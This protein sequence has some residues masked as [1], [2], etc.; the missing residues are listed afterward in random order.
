MRRF[1]IL[2]LI[3]VFVISEGQAAQDGGDGRSYIVSATDVNESSFNM[4]FHQDL[5]HRDPGPYGYDAWKQDW[6]N[7]PW[8]DGI[9]YGDGTV[10]VDHQG[11]GRS[12]KAMRWIFPEN[13]YSITMEHGY[14]W[15]PPLGG[16]YQEAYL[17]YSLMFK[18][19]FEPVL[20][21]KLPCLMGYPFD[22]SQDY[23]H[24]YYAGLMFKEG[25]KP[26]F[27]LY[28]H[29]MA[30]EY[31]E[32]R[33]WNFDFDVSQEIWYDIT[34]RVV[35][36]TVSNGKGN[37]DGIIEGYVNGVLVGQWTNLR[38]RNFDNIG[39]NAAVMQAF[40]G[41]GDPSW[42]TIRDEW[43]LIDNVSVWQ[44]SSLFLAENPNVKR[45]LQ[46]GSYGDRIV[47][48]IDLLSGPIDPPPVDDTT[49]PSIPSGLI[50]TDSTQTSIS[51]GWDSSTDN[52]G[53]TGYFIFKDGFMLGSTAEKEY[54]V[55]NLQASTSYELAVSS[56]DASGNESL[57]SESIVVYTRMLDTI[58]PS[59]PQNL[60]SGMITGYSAEISWDPATD[61]LGVGYYEIFVNGGQRHSTEEDLFII[62]SLQPSLSYNVSVRAV[63]VSG[64]IGPFSNTIAIETGSLDEDPPSKPSELRQ[65]YVSETSVELAWKPSVDNESVSKYKIFLN[66]QE[67]DESTINQ[68]TIAGLEPGISYI[69]SVSALDEALNESPR[70][71]PLEV[72]T[73]NQD[74]TTSPTL[75]NISIINLEQ[76]TINPS[77]LTEM[78]SLGYVEMGYFG[79][80]ASE[81]NS[82]VDSPVVMDGI[83]SAV[84]LSK[85]RI[86]NGIQALYIFSEGE[87]DIVKD[88]AGASTAMDL[89]ISRAGVTTEWMSGQGLKVLDKTNIYYPEKPT[90][91]INALKETNEVTIEAWVKQE[92]STQSGFAQL[93]SLYKDQDS[94]GITLAYDGN[95]AFYNYMAMV[96]TTTSNSDGSPFVE[97]TENFTSSSLH[98]LVYTRNNQGLEKMFV[99]GIEFYSGQ[100]GGDFSSWE[101]DYI[102]SLVGN[103]GF[104]VNPWRGIYYLVAIYNKAH[105]SEEVINNYQEG[106]GRVQYT[107]YLNSLKVN[108]EY[109]LTPFVRTNQGTVYGDPVNYINR[110]VSQTDSLMV[111]YPNPS[112][113]KLKIVVNSKDENVK[114]AYLRVSDFSGRVHYSRKIDLFDGL[115]E[116]VLAIELPHD[117]PSGIYSIMLIVGTKS[118]AE[119]LVLLR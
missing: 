103:E 89:Q 90:R 44:Y 4:I 9:T 31:G 64:N 54:I 97:S 10:I 73:K 72:T 57:R 61:N 48:P 114:E 39:T 7:P 5:D 107:N 50:A 19:G 83:N 32:T 67:W 80:E 23:D 109:L 35:M 12:S 117:M 79:L 116:N 113:G 84:Y 98:H 51:L 21:G 16:E 65:T 81:K 29:D 68:R 52:V 102:F 24:G 78:S 100:R 77:A 99:N 91:L 33:Y 22:G 87:G 58:E 104:D 47:T 62:P 30:I 2:P 112:S 42:S 11:G 95:A 20:G 18:P 88:W 82:T 49:P 59:A 70:S 86:G 75:P 108:V 41:G 96:N 14:Q 46:A 119:K 115:Y 53:V 56:Y 3:F 40:F 66:G 85:D 26:V 110:N 8:G 36:N 6:N 71:D 37:N 92:Q 63:D 105:K 101:D 25:P 74:L 60:R 69:F 55:S 45:G 76:N 34:L 27:Y 15:R 17:T 28:H 106:I 93:V 13:S 38:L 118:V 111:I 1:I 43:M 94:R